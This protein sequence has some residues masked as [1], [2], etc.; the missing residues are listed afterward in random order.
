MYIEDTYA[1]ENYNDCSRSSP[2]STG[3][4]LS[5][6]SEYGGQY[7]SY[8]SRLIALSGDVELNTG[9]IDKVSPVEVGLDQ[10]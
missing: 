4:T 7:G 8:M 2:T 10:L 9:Q 1:W 5:I 6:C 3:Y